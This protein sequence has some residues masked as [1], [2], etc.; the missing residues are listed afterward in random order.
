MGARS[1]LEVGEYPV[2]PTPV[3][4]KNT[5][6]SIHIQTGYYVQLFE[7]TGFQKQSVF[8]FPEGH[9][10]TLPGWGDSIGSLKVF[11]YNPNF[12]PLVTF[13][14]NSGFTGYTQTLAGTG[15]VTDYDAPFFNSYAISSIQVPAETK[16]ILYEG[17]NLTGN[18]LE[19]KTGK[20]ESL[21]IYGWDNKVSSVK[22]IRADL[23]L[24]KI[25]YLEEI[26]EEEGESFAIKG[27]TSNNSNIEQSFKVSLSRALSES[28]T[29]SW[30]DSTATG[31]SASV[32]ATVEVEGLVV[33]SSVSSTIESSLEHTFT[34]GEEEAVSKTIT[35]EKSVTVKIPPK[36][37]GEVS[38]IV[39]PKK[40][41]VKVRYSFLVKATSKIITQDAEIYISS[42]QEGI[43]V[44]T[45]REETVEEM[46]L[47]RGI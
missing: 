22:I 25:E 6:N 36:L 10:S 19:L 4:G 20:H 24:T 16:V 14:E 29:R 30:S 23:V 27:I 7:G 28:I 46:N 15:K 21:K 41:R 26:V 38:V 35:L 8:L 43:S 39:T 2:V 44:I 5:I 40:Y 18:S 3:A 32:T 17:S 42:Y 1:S 45:I 47:S 12:F 13:Y 11:K 9:Y 37:V 31:L 34:V 33:K